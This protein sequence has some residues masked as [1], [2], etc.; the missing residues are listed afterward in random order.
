MPPRSSA[1]SLRQ[2]SAALSL[3]LL[4]IAP[5][6]EATLEGIKA[7]ESLKIRAR[8]RRCLDEWRNRS[9]DD[10]QQQQRSHDLDR[11]KKKKNI[12]RAAKPPPQAPHV[13]GQLRLGRRRHRRRA[14]VRPNDAAHQPQLRPG[15]GARP[16]RGGRGRVPPSP[17]RWRGRGRRDCMHD[18]DRAG[19]QRR[20]EH[21][22]EL[23]WA[24]LCDELE[25]REEREATMR[26]REREKS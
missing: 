7:G 6:A 23:R 5:W 24:G 18:F 14:V 20:H 8:R 13:G 9:L 4:F 2:F 26:E 19:R 1:G 17:Q 15:G 11:E 3:L 22:H 12:T 25:L 10:G 21:E 16:A